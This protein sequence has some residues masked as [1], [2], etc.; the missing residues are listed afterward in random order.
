MS[1]PVDLHERTASVG[2]HPPSVAR[3]ADE[4][5]ASVDLWGRRR[6][7]KNEGRICRAGLRRQIGGDRI[8]WRPANA[9]AEPIGEPRGQNPACARWGGALSGRDVLWAN[10]G[11][12]L[13]VF[14]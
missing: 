4:E 12:A 2:S 10:A 6:P 11:G 14:N 7:T 9:F 8:A 13:L 1:D 3:K 5:D